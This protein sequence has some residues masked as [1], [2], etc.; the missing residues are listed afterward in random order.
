[1]WLKTY[2]KLGADR[3]AWAFVADVLMSRAVA[4]SSKGSEPI[5]R[6]NAFLQSWKVSTRVAAGLP[7][8]LRRMVKV[9]EKYGV[10]CEVQNPSQRLRNELPIWY[11]I[12]RGNGRCT[13]NS[14]ACKCLRANHGVRTTE[15]CLMVAA[16]LADPDVGHLPQGACPCTACEHDRSAYGCR[17]PH[18]CAIA[19]EKAV[20]DLKMMWLPTRPGNEDGLTLTRNRIL[21]NRTARADH[22]RI[23]FDPSLANRTPLANVFRAFVKHQLPDKMPALRVPRPYQVDGAE[24]EVYTDGS[25][26]RNGFENAAAGSGVW[27][28]EEDHRNEGVRVPYDEQTNQV[29]EMY[30]VAVAHRKVPPFVPL[31]IVSDSTYVVDGLTKHLPHW[32]QRGWIGVANADIIRDVAALLRSRSAL[33]TFR[34]VKGHARTRGNEEADKLAG[35]GARLDRQL[36][37]VHLP[38]LEH[39]AVKG[40]KLATITQKLAYRGIR[41]WKPVPES[42]TMRQ[43]VDDVI[44]ALQSA[45]GLRV[46]PPTLW[47][48]L[49]AHPIS[50]KCRDFLWKALHGAHKIGKYWENIPGYEERARCPVCGVTETMDHILTSCTAPGQSAAWCSAAALLRLKGVNIFPISAGHSRG[51]HAFSALDEEGEL[52]QGPT[53]LARIILTETAYLIWVLRCERVIGRESR[54]P[55]GV[56]DEL[57]KRR[58]LAA[59]NKR[60][61]M[62]CALTN[63]ARAGRM[64]VAPDVVMDTW[65][66]VLLNETGLPAAWTDTEGVLVGMPAPAS[67]TDR[68]G[69]GESHT[70]APEH[71]LRA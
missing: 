13:A 21:Q 61:R 68:P 70:G 2:L 46:L 47:H 42:R 15:Q 27:F 25:C 51:G 49:R 45:T 7:E 35:E 28:G 32:E 53:R 29:A 62:D 16:R 1:M 54:Q 57:V 55:D 19:A 26:V 17:N 6:V 18:R 24:V 64:F 63:K 44:S 9:A 39:F 58:W 56:T 33:T 37:P 71:R 43:N 36:R 34:W 8:S 65:S 14:P 20:N 60:L 11:H 30:A 50:K 52:R 31:H 41:G 69:A 22:G 3:P 38:P 4:A 12:G 66:G 5:S 59:V 48:L 67:P 23:A 10:R 40:A